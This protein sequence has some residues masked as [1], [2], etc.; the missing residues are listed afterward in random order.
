MMMFTSSAAS[1]AAGNPLDA[2]PARVL[3]SLDAG[4]SAAALTAPDMASQ[5]VW[6]VA[7]RLQ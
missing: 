4:M 6:V 3:T 7:W 5:A 1:V 2:S